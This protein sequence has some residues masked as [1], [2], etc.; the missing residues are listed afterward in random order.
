MIY[1][2]ISGKRHVSKEQSGP[3]SG[4]GR[5]SESNFFSR[6][7]L[8]RQGYLIEK[9]ISFPL[10]FDVVKNDYNEN[11]SSSSWTCNKVYYT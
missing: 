8:E 1:S 11:A 6:D 2:Y 7:N 10:L 3:P 5:S 4:K 9:M